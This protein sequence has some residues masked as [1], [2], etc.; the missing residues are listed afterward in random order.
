[1]LMGGDRFVGVIVIM[2]MERTPEKF[3]P[4]RITV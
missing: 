4:L 3:I 1:M 2:V